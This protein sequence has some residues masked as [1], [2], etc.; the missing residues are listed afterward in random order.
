M[1][2]HAEFIVF[3]AK[4]ALE[5]EQFGL[6]IGVGSCNHT[7][8]ES[9]SISTRCAFHVIIHIDHAGLPARYSVGWAGLVTWAV[10]RAVA[11]GFNAPLHY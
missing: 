1:P 2:T 8:D 4:Q 11:V 5:A 3:A 10:S 6:K 9:A 7:F